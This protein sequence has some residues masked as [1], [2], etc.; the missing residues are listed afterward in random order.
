MVTLIRKFAIILTQKQEEVLQELSKTCR[1]L[2]NHALAERTFL[3][4]TYNQ[5]QGISK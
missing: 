5:D 2:Y 1:L 4:E 3:Y